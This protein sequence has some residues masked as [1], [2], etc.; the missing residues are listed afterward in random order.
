M[1]ASLLKIPASPFRSGF[2]QQ[3]YTIHKQDQIFIIHPYV[4]AFKRK[5]DVMKM[6][7]IIEGYY[8]L[9]SAW[10]M[11]NFEDPII[12]KN[13]DKELKY[14]DIIEWDFE[15]ISTFCQLNSFGL[16]DI[17]AIEGSR[18]KGT[19]F[20]WEIPLELQVDFLESRL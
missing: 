8:G 18:L 12:I 14:I 6:S 7:R 16:M 2:G 13:T 4:L 1:A 5:R 15:S 19:R 17:H 3:R 11:I 10:P 9:I 20:H